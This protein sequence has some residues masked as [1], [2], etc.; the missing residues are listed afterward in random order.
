MYSSFDSPPPSPGDGLKKFKLHIKKKDG[1]VVGVCP[2]ILQNESDDTSGKITSNK[3]KFFFFFA[4]SEFFPVYLWGS[5]DLFFVFRLSVQYEATMP[6]IN[7]F[8]TTYD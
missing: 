8:Q 2:Y 7:M 1:S 4:F 6:A 3:K 5:L